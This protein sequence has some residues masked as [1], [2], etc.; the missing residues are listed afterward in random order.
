MDGFPHGLNPFERA[1][2][3]S[4]SLFIRAH[5]PHPEA[6]KFFLE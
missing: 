4:S 3:L 1:D 2:D 6:I 5:E